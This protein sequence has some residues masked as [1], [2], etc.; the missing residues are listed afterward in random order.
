MWV[1]I[2]FNLNSMALVKWQPFREVDSFFDNFP[3]LPRF[4][5]DLAV[6]VYEESGNVIAKLNLPGIDPQKIDVEVE[7]HHLRIS[8]TRE[9]EKEEKT[10][11]YYS[12]EIRRG[13]FERIVPL[14]CAVKKDK[15]TAEYKNGELKV[16]LPKMEKDKSGKVKIEVK[17]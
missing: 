16:T 15:V 12:K 3:A 5:L 9:E 10:K 13:S 2:F 8:G 14:P 7:D 17:K 11:H 1:A 4:E 6:D